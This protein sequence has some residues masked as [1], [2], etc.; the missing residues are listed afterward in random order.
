M[1]HKINLFSPDLLPTYPWYHAQYFIRFVLGLFL[2]LGLCFG[3]TKVYLYTLEQDILERQSQIDELTMQND[4]LRQ[5]V[6][7]F[8]RTHQGTELLT[9]QN[10]IK[11]YKSILEQVKQTQTH[12][13]LR[14][15][16]ILHSLAKIKT[17]GLWL[18]SIQINLP[19]IIF[20]GLVIQPESLPSWVHTL[21]QDDAFK[22]YTFS[23]IDMEAITK[24][25]QQ[26]QFTVILSREKP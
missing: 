9:L 14:I 11:H 24:K 15:H 3:A 5:D 22:A 21:K 19:K 26:V 25:R 18:T 23:H 1:K 16:P 8:L 6:E 13:N 2:A 20:K 7:D 10:K 17:R 12:N 4:Q